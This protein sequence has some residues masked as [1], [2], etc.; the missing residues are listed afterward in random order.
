[1]VGLAVGGVG[2]VGGVC[3]WRRAWWAGLAVGA[4]GGQW[5]WLEVV[6]LFVEGAPEFPDIHALESLF[7][8][9]GSD[10]VRMNGGS[11]G[12]AVGRD[13]GNSRSALLPRATGAVAGLP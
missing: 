7:L 11:Y 5:W 2:G 1:M 4:H 13:R 8:R 6:S 10:P 12:L 9:V 3:G